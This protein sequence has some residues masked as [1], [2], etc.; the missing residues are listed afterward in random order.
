M[1][2]AEYLR[3]GQFSYWDW[4]WSLFDRKQPSDENAQPSDKEGKGPPIPVPGGPKSS[5]LAGP[6]PKIDNM[7]EEN[8]QRKIRK[9]TK[10]LTTQMSRNR[11]K[12][13]KH[14]ELYFRSTM[15]RSLHTG[16]II[17]DLKWR[18]KPIKKPRLVIIMDTSGSMSAYVKM[19][20]Q[21]IQGVNRELNDFEL[22]IFSTSLGHVT[23]KIGATWQET[24]ANLNDSQ[25]WGGGT[26]I[27]RSVKKICKN[28]RKVL[29]RSSVII[30]LSDLEDNNEEVTPYLNEMRAQVKRFYVF[31]TAP[32]REL[33]D[34]D[35]QEICLK[36]FEDS[37]VDRIFDV[38]TLDD[39]VV[40]VKKVC[41]R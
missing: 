41:I 39:M 32:T 1:D 5:K 20:L 23:D 16:G 27:T 17:I 3:E 10:Q 14:K 29:T 9:I 7:D 35:Y 30:F 37:R 18:A 22:F 12:T 4:M 33:E 31:N 36:P 38:Q 28:Y 40:A 2:T 24:M 19:L 6:P 15:K 26:E 11:K 21:I 25:G 34:E 8:V 13:K